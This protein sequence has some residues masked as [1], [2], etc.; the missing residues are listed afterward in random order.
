MTSIN[1]QLWIDTTWNCCY[2]VPTVVFCVQS[3]VSAVNS[4]YFSFLFSVSLSLS[5][6]RLFAFEGGGRGVGGS[7]AVFM[8]GAERSKVNSCVVTTVKSVAVSRH[9]F[10][11]T[12]LIFTVRWRWWQKKIRA[13][14]QRE[15]DN[16]RKRKKKH[17]ERRRRSR[18]WWRRRE[19]K[20]CAI[21][22]IEERRHYISVH[23]G[24]TRL[25]PGLL[26]LRFP[27]T[28]LQQFDI[29]SSGQQENET[30]LGGINSADRG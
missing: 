15:E 30:G 26:H 20:K 8:D 9:V 28:T 1:E 17:S 14:K 2:Q 6:L 5:W 4:S 13:H 16:A 23:S 18:R 27:P 11:S 25:P 22:F 19:K 12:N 10:T 21:N 7:S 24:G 3:R 29:N